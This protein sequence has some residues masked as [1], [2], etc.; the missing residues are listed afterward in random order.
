MWPSRQRLTSPTGLLLRRD[1]SLSHHICVMAGW[2]NS[3]QRRGRTKVL[4]SKPVYGSNLLAAIT[5]VVLAPTQGVL[6]QTLLQVEGKPYVIHD[7]HP[8]EIG[9][10]RS[11]LLLRQT[12]P[13]GHHTYVILKWQSSSQH[14]WWPSGRVCLNKG[15]EWWPPIS[16]GCTSCIT[17]SL[18]TTRSRVRPSTPCVGASA[19]VIAARRLEPCLG[20]ESRTF[21]PQFC[22]DELCHSAIT[23]VGWLRLSGRARVNKKS[24]ANIL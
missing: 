5:I 23:H 15:E 17:C 3:S 8:Q 14:V 21:V 1:L 18:P 19:R 13:L 4:G 9:G 22:W 2:Q 6:V 12:L 11:S 10:H 16:R 20:F 24:S 7:V